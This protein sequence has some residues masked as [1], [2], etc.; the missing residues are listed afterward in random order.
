[1]LTLITVNYNCADRT[2][3]LLRSLERQTNAQF[4]IIV[5]DNDSR[6][7]D[8]AALG[9]YATA[10]PLALDIIHAPS[11]LGFSG[12]NNLAIRK[13]LAQ[14]TVWTLLINPDTDVGPEFIARIHQATDDEPAVWGLPLQEGDGRTAYA[15]RVRWLR[16]TLPHVYAWPLVRHVLEEPLYAIGAGMLVHR[17]AWDRIGL[18]DERYFL[19][20][21]DA[22]F[23]MRARAAGVSVRF[24]REPVIRH[25]V[26][27]STSALGSPLLLRYHVRNAL[28][29]N[30]RHGPLWA[31]ISLHFWALSI[32]LKQT[33][34]MVSMPAR[35]PQSRAILA[36]IADFYARRFGRIRTHAHRH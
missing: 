9:A 17:D 2:L 30:A 15:G 20:F 7:A 21:E 3:R 25:A 1:M 35:R 26:S 23:G 10:S 5:V 11:N 33:A 18:L 34:K 4:S 8:R 29:M 22:D 13:A 28:L 6:P 36:G 16:A 12:G 24:L 31:R 14:G 27:A 19:Y 32:M